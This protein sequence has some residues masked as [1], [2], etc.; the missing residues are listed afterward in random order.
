MVTTST[1]PPTPAAPKVGAP[2]E[3]VV[4]AAPIAGGPEL[5]TR[6]NESPEQPAPPIVDPAEPELNLRDHL[7][8]DAHFHDEN[9]ELW[10]TALDKMLLSR[11]PQLTF[12][13]LSHLFRRSPL[14]PRIPIFYQ[15]VA[16]SVSRRHVFLIKLMQSTTKELETT[17]MRVAESLFYVV[18]RNTKRAEDDDAIAALVRDGDRAVEVVAELMALFNEQMATGEVVLRGWNRTC[19]VVLWRFLETG[20]FNYFREKERML[21]R[22]YGVIKFRKEL[23]TLCALVGWT[24]HRMG[25]YWMADTA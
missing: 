20:I 8:P 4:E 18:R 7:P 24:L 12:T 25:S 17:L 2:E 22:R 14:N 1:A 5:T 23:A 19:V 6:E 16:H 15:A 11:T 9:R 3:P 13:H 10:S 21:E